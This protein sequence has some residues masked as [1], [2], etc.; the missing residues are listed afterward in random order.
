M[1]DKRVYM[2]DKLKR[3]LDKPHKS[4]YFLLGQC[5]RHVGHAEEKKRKE[6]GLMH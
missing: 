5:L 1:N 3:W 4:A 6:R 2:C